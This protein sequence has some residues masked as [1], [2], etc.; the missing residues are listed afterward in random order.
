MILLIKI[1]RT[2][3]FTGY[4]PSKLP[5][6]NNE[7]HPACLRLKALIHDT[8]EAAIHDGYTH[9]ICGFALGSDTYF[10]EAV[11]VLRT[12]YPQITLEAALACEAQAENW[13]QKDR[14]RFYDLL[15]R[16]DVET[17]I[18]RK[19]YPRCYLDRNRY[20]VDHSRRLIAVFDGKLGGTMYTVNRAQAKKIELV[21]INPSAY[22]ADNT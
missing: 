21:I 16:C 19:Y 10:A 3:G 6:P 13:A 15:S 12:L 17:Y 22:A 5:F 14:D 11:L 2:C 20:I 1:L 18:S 4:R 9:F 7:K 8:V